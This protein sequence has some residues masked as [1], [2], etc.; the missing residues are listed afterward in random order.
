MNQ[1]DSNLPKMIMSSRKLEETITHSH[2]V[3]DTKIHLELE[4]RCQCKDSDKDDKSMIQSII[5]NSKNLNLNDNDVII[6]CDSSTTLPSPALDQD[7]DIST[8][9]SNSSPAS[10]PTSGSLMMGNSIIDAETEVI[11]SKCNCSKLIPLKIQMYSPYTVRGL[12]KDVVYEYCTCGQT[13]NQP[14]CD[15]SHIGTKYKPIEFTLD[16]NQI[17]NTLLFKNISSKYISNSIGVR[18]SSFVGNNRYFSS[19]KVTASAEPPSLITS[20]E[21]FKT[22]YDFKNNK[23]RIF[24]GMQPTSGGLHL[25]NYVGAMLNWVEIQN[26]ILSGDNNQQQQHDILF[27]IVDLHSLTNKAVTPERLRANTLDVAIE[28]ISCGIDPT[29]VILFNQSQVSAHAELQW[30]LSCHTAIGRLEN[31][32]Q[33]KEKSKKNTS[34]LVQN[35]YG[36]LA[37]PI[38]MAA[39]ILLYKA[40]HVPVGEDQT[41]HVELTRK[42]AYAFNSHHKVDF[43]TLPQI[44][45]C[46]ETKRIMSLTDASTKMSKSDPSENSRINLTDSDKI[47]TNK[48]MKAAT[49]STVGVS[50]DPENRANISNLLSIASAATGAPITDIAH[51]FKDQYH[52]KFKEYLAQQL[53]KKITPIRDQIE[54]HRANPKQVKEYLQLGSQR[55]N[56]LAQNNLKEIKDLIG[57]YY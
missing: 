28:Y 51:E 55:A 16:R 27:S 20:I 12:K 41:Q 4:N 17:M 47:I 39:D 32:V 53:C 21:Q 57:L 46:T 36:L 7:S 18:C 10:N 22:N 43:F 37:Y 14:F 30:I 15:K 42:I 29:K 6:G 9:D 34:S 31:M 11:C 2:E 45:N 52:S 56:Q 33:Y 25:G 54:Y 19:S 13:K 1:T 24:S 35:T 3:S 5:A 40:S 44:V 48:I 26:T 49:D 23:V 50:Y 8:D 38:L